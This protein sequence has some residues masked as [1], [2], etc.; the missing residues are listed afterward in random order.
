MRIRKILSVVISIIF[1]MVVLSGCLPQTEDKI[2]IG[3][4]QFTQFPTLDAVRQGFTMRMREL[5]YIDGLNSEFEYK[6]ANGSFEEANEIVDNFIEDKKDIIISISTPATTVAMKAA[7]KIPVVF[8][9]VSDP[10]GAGIVDSLEST[11]RNITG[12]SNVIRIKEN[13]DLAFQ[14]TPNIK[15]LGYIY[16]PAEQ[17]SIKS[18]EGIKEY[19]KGKDVEII[20]TTVNS[21]AEVP[22]AAQELIQK[23]DSLFVPNDNTVAAVMPIIAKMAIDAKIPAYVGLELMVKENGLANVGI[24]YETMGK[25]TAN[26]AAEILGG[27]RQAKDIPVEI[28]SDDL[29]TFINIDTAKKIGLTIPDKILGAPKTVLYTAPK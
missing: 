5:G 21:P 16:N 25:E 22:A 8:A 11:G 29:Y 13:L 1:C 10:V 14:L 18:L 2:K 7:D 9:A 24:R 12:T 26:I 20:E 4:I 27:E 28:L 23:V 15:K 19:L 6:S 17:N 3:I